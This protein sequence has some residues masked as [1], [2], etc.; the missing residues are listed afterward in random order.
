VTP[1]AIDSA[2]IYEF[3]DHMRDVG[4]LP[5][6]STFRR[7]ALFLTEQFLSISSLPSSRFDANALRQQLMYDAMAAQR[8]HPL[9]YGLVCVLSVLFCCCLFSVFVS[10]HFCTCS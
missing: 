7:I 3:M 10:C 9:K 2:S 1:Q 6:V 4:V 5:Q 8:I